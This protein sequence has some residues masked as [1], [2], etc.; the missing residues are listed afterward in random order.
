M[1]DLVRRT[2]SGRVDLRVVVGHVYQCPTQVSST[3]HPLLVFPHLLLHHSI[4]LLLQL[5]HSRSLLVSVGLQ[6]SLSFH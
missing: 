1:I 4:R 6:V 3:G 2:G 5:Q